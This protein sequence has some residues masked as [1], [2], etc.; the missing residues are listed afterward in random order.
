MQY[1]WNKTRGFTLIETLV[2]I[3]IFSIGIVAPLSVAFY[4]IRAAEVA[5]DEI[6][7]FYFAEEGVEYIRHVR[8]TNILEGANWLDDL[9]RCR[10]ASGC[11]PVDILENVN[12]NNDFDNCGGANSCYLEFDETTGLYDAN[13]TIPTKFRRVIRVN[14]INSNE[15]EVVSTVSWTTRTTDRSVILRDRMFNWSDI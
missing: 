4:A 1:F 6:S 12:A 10:N 7:G 2:A 11:N 8:D 9:T 5:R 13:G 15:V 3:T 14:T